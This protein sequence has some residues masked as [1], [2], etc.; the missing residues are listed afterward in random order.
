MR[1]AIV[2]PR[3][4]DRAATGTSPALRFLLLPEAPSLCFLA[5]LISIL[6]LTTPGFLTRL[7]LE[8][9]LAQVAVLGIVA[10]AVNQVILAG[11][12]DVS[13]GSL[14][15]VC[16][17]VYGE[18]AMRGGGLL[19]PLLAS[20][21]VGLT[22]GV[23]NGLLVTNARIPSIIAT[24]GTLNVLRG[25]VLLAAADVVL[26]ISG[27][28]RALGIGALLGVSTPVLV[29]I[30][31]YL[32]FELIGRQTTWGR[33]VLAVG[34]NRRA[35]RLAG[36]PIDGIRLRA[37]ALVGLCCGL[38][39]AVFLGQIGQ[40]QATAATGFELQVI[41]AVVIGGTSLTGGRGSNVAPLV[42]AFLI[43]VI[44]NGM[45]LRAVPGTYQDVVLGILILLAIATDALRRRLVG[46][47]L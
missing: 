6:S 26:N 37:F 31:A 13:T 40:L 2:A 30:G 10:L 12:I 21:G 45:T 25:A 8:G 20:L 46:R 32:A 14:V 47:I 7:N 1:A 4:L 36:L 42:G 44:L 39:A 11:E 27:R 18:V 9:V 38:A 34:G 29:L 17:F 15:A 41:A 43:G 16:A 33:D 22:V 5:L 19:M 24:L 28:S 35:A 23:I 3:R